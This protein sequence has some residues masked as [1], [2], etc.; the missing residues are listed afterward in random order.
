MNGYITFTG[1]KNYFFCLTDNYF[2]HTEGR[3][4]PVKTL[5]FPHHW[6]CPTHKKREEPKKSICPPEQI[7]APLA[8]Q[9][10]L[11]FPKDRLSIIQNQNV[12]QKA[13]SLET[14]SYHI[15][16]NYTKVT[17][18]SPSPYYK[19]PTRYRSSFLK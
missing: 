10:F 11:D 18:R 7:L 2:M 9:D 17:K 3:T 13:K 5:I 6:P 19:F 4:K 15:S 8:P 12:L 1:Q 16:Y 14:T